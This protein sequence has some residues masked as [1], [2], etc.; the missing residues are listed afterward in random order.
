M[1]KLPSAKEVT[2]NLWLSDGTFESEMELVRNYARAVL[3][4]AAEVAENHIYS[5]EVA[6]D[7]RALKEDL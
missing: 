5:E 3:E 1:A 2:D 7:I 6:A 4:A